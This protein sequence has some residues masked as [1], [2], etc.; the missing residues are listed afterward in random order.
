MPSAI[1]ADLL[2]R[3]IAVALNIKEVPPFAC[4]LNLCAAFLSSVMQKTSFQ[5]KA[6][7]G[8]KTEQ[9]PA[10]KLFTMVN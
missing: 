7:P 8:N 1:K 4:S 5:A 10:P 9:A 6:E 2:F 3:N